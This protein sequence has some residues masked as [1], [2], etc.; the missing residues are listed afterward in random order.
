MKNEDLLRLKIAIKTRDNLAFQEMSLLLDR[1]E[2]LKMLPDLRK[3]YKV[4]KLMRLD[5]YFGSTD[6]FKLEDEVKINLKKYKR[7]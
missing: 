1:P 4:K 7:L 6:N 5:E 2:F 3:T